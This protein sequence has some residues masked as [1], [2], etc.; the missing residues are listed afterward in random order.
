MSPDVM[1]AA[2]ETYRSF[3]HA[4]QPVLDRDPAAAPEVVVQAIRLRMHLLRDLDLPTTRHNVDRLVLCAAA[5]LPLRVFLRD[6]DHHLP[7]TV[8][9]DEALFLVALAEHAAARELLTAHD[10][11]YD[12]EAFLSL[13]HGGRSS[14]I[15]D[16][17]LAG[18]LSWTD[19]HVWLRRDPIAA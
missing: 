6:V 16:A 14:P 10:R 7:P 17:W 3:K 4:L 8:L 18:A 15:V 12:A 19:L 13:P 9:Q 1:S 5:D 11:R 2:R